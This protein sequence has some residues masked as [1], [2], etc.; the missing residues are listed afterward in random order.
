MHA[1][2]NIPLFE[3]D[4]ISKKNDKWRMQCIQL[5]NDNN[6]KN[7]KILQKSLRDL[8]DTPDQNAWIHQL[9][10]NE[11]NIIYALK[12]YDMWMDE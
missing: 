1:L 9:L 4:F 2:K 12:R 3:I 11:Q 5:K 8:F 6:L 7:L 10:T